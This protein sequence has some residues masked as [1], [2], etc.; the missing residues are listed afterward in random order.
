DTHP[1]LYTK[2]NL[3]YII[4]GENIREADVQRSIDLTD[5]IYCGAIAMIRPK[6]DV[7][8]SFII[9]DGT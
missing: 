9:E 2:I 1:Q 6:V 5:E 3:H 8:H 4:T 7:T